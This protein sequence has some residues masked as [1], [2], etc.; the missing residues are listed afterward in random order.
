MYHSTASK[1]RSWL[2]YFLQGRE[3]ELSSPQHKLIDFIHTIFKKND[4]QVGA[5]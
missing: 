2:P 1:A 5:A 3:S 4:Q